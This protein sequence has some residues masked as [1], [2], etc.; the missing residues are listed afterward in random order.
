MLTST[1]DVTT[2]DV[3]AVVGGWPAGAAIDGQCCE[4]GAFE[5]VDEFGVTRF[6][7]IH[8][9]VARFPWI[10]P[11]KE[12]Q[13]DGAGYDS[14]LSVQQVVERQRTVAEIH[15]EEYKVSTTGFSGRYVS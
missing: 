10:C 6:P 1:G 14:T 13:G 15:T 2:N 5:M 7:N 11:R 3:D 4:V 9:H 8:I 12:G